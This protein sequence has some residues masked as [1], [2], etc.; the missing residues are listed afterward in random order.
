MVKVFVLAQACC[1]FRLDSHSLVFAV[2]II[3]IIIIIVIIKK[4]KESKKRV[5]LIQLTKL[6]LFVSSL[7]YSSN[8]NTK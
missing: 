7:K 8:P 5:N 4:G 1:G 2:K 3:I 6:V